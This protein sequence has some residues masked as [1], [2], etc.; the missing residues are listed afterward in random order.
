[1]LNL[2]SFDV[3]KTLFDKLLSKHGLIKL[4][5]NN[6]FILNLQ[7]FKVVYFYVLHISDRM[8]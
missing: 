3:I 7:C 6:I 2:A 5:T 1:M 8:M 4:K